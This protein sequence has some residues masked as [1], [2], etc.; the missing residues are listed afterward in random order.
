MWRRELFDSIQGLDDDDDDDDDVD[1]RFLAPP[2]LP[3]SNVLWPKFNRHDVMFGRFTFLGLK[4]KSLAFT[5]S[6]FNNE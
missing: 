5:V 6:G 4:I 3:P 2:M 1:V